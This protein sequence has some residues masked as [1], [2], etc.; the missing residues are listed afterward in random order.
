[1]K[2]TSLGTW[3]NTKKHKTWVL[4]SNSYCPV[5]ET[6]TVALVH[7]ACNKYLFVLVN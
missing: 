4:P 6:V 5:K 2:G 7:L 1:M 3:G